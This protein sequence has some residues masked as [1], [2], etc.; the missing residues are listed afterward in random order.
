MV[1]CTIERWQPSLMSPE[2]WDAFV[3][4][5]DNGTIF[6]ERRFLSYHPPERFCDHSLVIYTKGKIAAVLPAVE[7]TIDR[8]KTLF[9]H[10]GASYGGF[11]YSSVSLAEALSWV[12]ELKKYARR[13]GFSRILMTL[14]PM[15]YARRPT[16]YC[17]FAL[18]SEGFR[19]QKRELTAVLAIPSSEEQ[20]ASMLKQEARTAAR[21]ARKTGVEVRRSDDY[22]SYYEILSHN[23]MM[24]HGVTP[25]HTLA[26]LQHLAE[27]FPERIML[28]AAFLGER[29]IAGV[30]NFRANQRTMLG[31]YIS[32]NKQFQEY[33]ALNLLFVEVFRRCVAEGIR[34]YDFGTFTLNMQPN[35]GLGKFKE[36]FGA[37]GIFRDTLEIW[38]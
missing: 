9:S 37:R 25:T 34:W 28:D 6:H 7:W 29:M 3:W 8:D 18:V 22:V 33:R 14:P 23:L 35:F 19:Y 15:L 32:D 11:V 2:E 20:V 24:R 30:V 10:R 36:T 38:L 13:A 26:E 27:L 1:H 31:F 17:D 16:N 4:S 5:S 21:K 12:Q